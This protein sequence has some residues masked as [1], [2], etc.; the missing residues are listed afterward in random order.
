VPGIVKVIVI[1]EH[2]EMAGK[3]EE[4]V[5]TVKDRFMVFWIVIP[6]VL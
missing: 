2:C 6:V 1:C 5:L 3:P 4:I